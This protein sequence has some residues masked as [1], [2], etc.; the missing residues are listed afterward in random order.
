MYVCQCVYVSW[1]SYF[2][3]VEDKEKRLQGQPLVKLKGVKVWR[4]VLVVTGGCSTWSSL[5]VW[6]ARKQIRHGSKEGG[7]GRRERE[8]GGRG[9]R[10]REEGGRG[11]R[12][13][14]GG[15]REREEGGNQ[16]TATHLT[17]SESDS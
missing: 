9:R 6:S 3:I 2:H 7:R 15:G 16:V 1:S 8:E 4:R 17:R 5:D 12:E 11:R 14:E 10:E 13:G